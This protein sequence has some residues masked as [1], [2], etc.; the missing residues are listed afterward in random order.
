MPSFIM[1]ALHG[2][3]IQVYGTGNQIMDMV[4]VGDVAR[5]LV[6]TLKVTIEQG[7]ALESVIEAGTGVSTSVREVALEVLRAVSGEYES[8]DPFAFPAPGMEFLPMRAGESASLPVLAD[9]STLAAIYGA[10]GSGF[11]PLRTGVRQT[12]EYYRSCLSK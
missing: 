3:P 12:V 6:D 1:K 7:K 11:V 5:I 9:T 8:H 10:Y 2:M 4:Y